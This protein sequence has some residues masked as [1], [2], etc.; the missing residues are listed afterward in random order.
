MV[1]DDPGYLPIYVGDHKLRYRQNGQSQSSCPD[2]FAT[3]AK[4][5]KKSPRG[6][7]EYTITTGNFL[8]FLLLIDMVNGSTIVI[9]PILPR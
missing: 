3:T 2:Y 7:V 6:L 9:P 4:K 5:Y 8:L 1:D